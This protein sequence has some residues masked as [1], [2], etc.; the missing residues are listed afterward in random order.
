MDYD[1]LAFK[2]A[3]LQ[4][5]QQLTHSP[6]FAADENLYVRIMGICESIEGDLQIAKTPGVYDG[7]TC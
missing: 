3:Y 7:R 5:L 4:E 2:L 6:H 1:K